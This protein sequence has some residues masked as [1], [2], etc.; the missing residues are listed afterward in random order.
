[1]R[2]TTTI[3]TAAATTILFGKKTDKIHNYRATSDV[4]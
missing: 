1:M 3:T 2:S 4:S